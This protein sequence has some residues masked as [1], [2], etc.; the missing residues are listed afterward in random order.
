MKR[1]HLHA[2][3]LFYL[4]ILPLECLANDPVQSTVSPAG[5]WQGEW[6]SPRGYIYV[7]EMHLQDPSGGKIE[8]HINWTLRKSP[9]AHEQSKLGSTGTEFVKGSYEL[10]SR[11]LTLDGYR[12]TDPNGVLGLDKYRLIFAENG[13]VLGGI[14]WNH[15]SWSG[16]IFLTRPPK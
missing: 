11:V 1:Y 16:Q 12:K 2:L 10:T 15:G 4:L 6:S 9:R 7:A 5:I 3:L 13:K 8:G 14:T